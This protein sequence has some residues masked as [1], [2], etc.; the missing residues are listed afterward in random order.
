MGRV[1][2]RVPRTRV[3]LTVDP[4]R[5]VR[6][7]DAVVVEEPLTIRVGGIEVTTTMRTPGDDF[8]LAIGHLVAEGLVEP[9]DVEHAMHCTDVDAAGSPT[10]NVVDVTLRPGR[11]LRRW[12]DR[13]TEVASS[14]C[15]VCGKQSVDDALARLRPVPGSHWRF[16]VRT[17]PALVDTMREAQS[18]FD[19]T[20]G[21]HAA[22]LFSATRELLVAREDVGRHNAVDKVIGA[23]ARAGALPL[24]DHVLLVS[25][26]AGF[27]IVQK[28]AAAGIPVLVAVSA[29]TSLAVD[30]AEASGL[31]LLAFAREDSV[32]AYTHPERLDLPPTGR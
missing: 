27:E 19:R 25:A 30:L 13:R 5:V 6:R 21:L 8:D 4:P 17:V 11:S 10:F 28:S 15:G 22:A 29:P 18:V 32:A 20:G 24:A 31:T 1:T 23:A 7:P 14:A 16:D 2:R 9:D 3:D 12:P 26:R